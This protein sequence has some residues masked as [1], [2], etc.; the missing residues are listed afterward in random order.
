MHLKKKNIGK[1][2]NVLK[3]VTILQLRWFDADFCLFHVKHLVDS[4]MWF[5]DYLRLSS[6]FA[7][8]WFNSASQ[9]M[10]N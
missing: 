4:A 10:I 1:E 6:L 9:T 2:N 3:I 5:Q 8:I 7:Y